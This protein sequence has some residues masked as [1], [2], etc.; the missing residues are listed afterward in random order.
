MTTLYDA[1]EHAKDAGI[2]N[3]RG[4]ACPL[5]MDCVR[6]ALARLISEGR[7]FTSESLWSM[8]PPPPFGT[9]SRAMGAVVRD[10]AKSGLIEP[11]GRY[12]EGKRTAS[13]KRPVREWIK[14]GHDHV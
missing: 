13:H 6:L 14:K 1:A 2:E 12:V 4:G 10:A 3:A 8:V 7:P 9:D 11:T 5:W